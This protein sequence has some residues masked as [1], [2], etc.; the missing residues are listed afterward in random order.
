MVQVTLVVVAAVTV[1]VLLSIMMLY[2]LVSDDKPVPAKV[3]EVPPVTVP[4]LGVIPVSNG[5]KAPEYVTV[6]DKV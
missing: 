2:L 6:S 1:Q 5:V 4:N 3:T